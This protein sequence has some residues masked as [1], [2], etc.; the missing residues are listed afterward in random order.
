MTYT[1]LGEFLRARR[2]QLDPHD[3]GLTMFSGRRRLAGLRREGLAQL[4]GV[5]VCYF[6]R[7]EQ[8]QYV[9][10]TD[11]VLDVLAAALRLDDHERRHLHTLAI[12]RPSRAAKVPAER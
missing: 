7:L 11:A 3:V 10:A 1:S 4:S 6:T 9:K 5:T 8:G 2:A 12:A